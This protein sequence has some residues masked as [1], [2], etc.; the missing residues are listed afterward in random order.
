MKEY[1]S[2]FNRSF[3]LLPTISDVCCNGWY[4]YSR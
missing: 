3:T 4:R 2:T 1:I